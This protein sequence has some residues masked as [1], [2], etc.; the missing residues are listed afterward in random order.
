[1]YHFDHLKAP[2][3]VTGTRWACGARTQ[4]SRQGGG[5]EGGGGGEG[6][7]PGTFPGSPGRAASPVLFLPAEIT[8]GT[9]LLKIVL[10]Y[11]EYHEVGQV[12][13]KKFRKVDRYMQRKMD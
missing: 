3:M 11:F 9:R 8:K 6:G 1:M 7:L 10:I 12:T 13:D 4:V 5:R 2:V